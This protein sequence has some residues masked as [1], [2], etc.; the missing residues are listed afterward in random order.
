MN[1]KALLLDVDG[2]LADTEAHGHLP[3]YNRAFRDLDLDWKWSRKLYRDL[4]AQPGGRERI[5]HYIDHYKPDLGAHGDR[6]RS[7]RAAW[8]RSVHERKSCRFRERLESGAV[9]LREGVERLIS[10]AHAQGMRI[11]IV[12]NASSASLEPFLQYALGRRLAG[13]IHAVVSGEQV[14]RKKPAPDI[15]RKACVEVQC[16]PHECVAIEDS[17]MGLRAA[18]AAGVPALVTINADTDPCNLDTACLV[19]DSLGEP[20]KPVQVIKPAEFAL[21]YVDVAVLR[22]LQAGAPQLPA[23]GGAHG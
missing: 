15:Y 8:V 5:E 23:A 9:P 2:T 21:E 12:T 17:A 13:Y 14:P 20:G 6:A 1:L 18:H 19:V 11:A 7:D 4:L 3:A 22:R 10:E 16:Q